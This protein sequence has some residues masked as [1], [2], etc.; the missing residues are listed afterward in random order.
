MS[1]LDKVI[2]FTIKDGKIKFEAQGFNGEG[3]A[4]ATRFLHE[5]GDTEQHQKPEYGEQLGTQR[6][7]A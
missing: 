2:E 7:R 6:L 3:C 1:G 4:D 5:L